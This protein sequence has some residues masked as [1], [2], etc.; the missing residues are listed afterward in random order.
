M[1]EDIRHLDRILDEFKLIRT[2][3]L[4]R[5][6]DLLDYRTVKAEQIELY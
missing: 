2:Q 6:Q 1:R 5:Y 4:D 3:R